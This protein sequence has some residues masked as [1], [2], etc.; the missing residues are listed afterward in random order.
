[1]AATNVQAFSG[2]VEI[3]SNLTAP[4]ITGLGYVATR[5]HTFNPTGNTSKYF[6]GWTTEEGMEIEINDSGF[7]HGSTQRFY[8]TYSY[9]QTPYLSSADVSDNKVYNFYYTKKNGR[10]YIWFN[11]TRDSSGNNVNYTIRMKTLKNAINLTEPG[12]AETYEG[13]VIGVNNVSAFP[14]PILFKREGYVGIGTTG[15]KQMF[16]VDSTGYGLFSGRLG[17]GNVLTSAQNGGGQDIW[18]AGTSAKLVVRCATS[19]NPTNT[20][21]NSRSFAGIAIVPGFDATDTTN[22]GLWGTA[23]GENPIFYIQNQVNNGQYGGSIA[24]NPVG[25]NVGIG[26]SDPSTKLYVYGAGNSSESTF[27][28]VSGN[29][30]CTLYLRD[31]GTSTHNGGAVLFGAGQG[32]FGAIKGGIT[33]GANNTRGRIHF[34]T[35]G[36]TNHTSL[37][38]RLSIYE[39]GMVHVGSDT[40]G[41][42]NGLLLQVHGP[43]TLG[44]TDGR[45]HIY[46]IPST[47]GAEPIVI[48]TAIDGRAYNAGTLARETLCLQPYA[49]QVGIGMTYPSQ[50]PFYLVDING[51]LRCNGFANSASDDRIKYNEEDVSN[52]LSLISQ[53]N[54]QKYEKLM[55]IPPNSEGTWIPTDEEWENVKEN[56]EHYEEFG[57]IAQ[58]VRNIP[59]LA[60]LVSGEET[61]MDIKFVSLEEYS[62][63]T[64]TDQSTYT[65]S[66][67]HKK[68]Y[69]TQEEY[70]NLTPEE[71]ETCI[72]RYTKQIET[73]TPLA[74][75]YQSLFVVA[76]AAI[77]E[78][79]AKNDALEARIS[80][81]ESA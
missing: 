76:I 12:A 80:A 49:G 23:S 31:S 72:I 70:S 21:A 14:A 22:M 66:Y 47:Y 63:L 20:Y 36:A 4:F 1:M 43:T 15:P 5:T 58:D 24:L 57:L 11:E 69:I 10:V 56:Y 32:S 79:K 35:R 2:D 26:V 8:I 7:S 9:D 39:N 16:E 46:A 81:L 71:Q 40:P 45:A 51:A 60:F 64:T 55:K 77:K 61:R 6:L 53:L 17:V 41:A 50:N 68:K 29:Q 78:L 52:A 38:K 3:S 62:N 27:E 44:S 13:T 28:T 25:G 65:I 18:N 74:L 67:L 59:E 33:D 37:S 42:T 19:I 48:Q 73:Q 30:G 54:P 34:F 75:N